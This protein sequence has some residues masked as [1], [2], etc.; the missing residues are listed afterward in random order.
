LAQIKHTD[1][2]LKKQRVPA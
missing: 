2:T 1:V